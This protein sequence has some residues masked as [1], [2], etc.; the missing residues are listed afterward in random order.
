VK[1]I[2]DAAEEVTGQKVP[3]KYGPRRAGDPPQLLANP[4]LAKEVLGWEATRKDVREMVKPAWAW[5][6]G[7]NGGHF[8]K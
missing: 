2:I 3:V 5:M 6:N 7:P 8:K 4:S 1:Q